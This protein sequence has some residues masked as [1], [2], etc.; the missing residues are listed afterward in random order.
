M[1]VK[2]MRQLHVNKTMTAKTF[3][4]SLNITAEI[5][6]IKNYNVI[7]KQVGFNKTPY[8]I[9]QSDIIM[10]HVRVHMTSF[11]RYTHVTS[12][13]SAVNSLAMQRRLT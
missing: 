2:V 6:L 10:L 11:T 12:Y 1:T 9:L 8:I 4:L 3:Q 5:Y 7:V 13:P